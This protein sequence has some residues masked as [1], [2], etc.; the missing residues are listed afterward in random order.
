VKRNI[1]L[2]FLGVVVGIA[3]SYAVAHYGF[4]RERQRCSEGM[5]SI[6]RQEWNDKQLLKMERDLA[7]E[8]AEYCTSHHGSFEGFDHDAVWKE[9]EKE[10]GNEASKP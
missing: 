5:S 1:W 9:L 3:S 10:Y 8:A 7:Q 4:M 2:F 6:R